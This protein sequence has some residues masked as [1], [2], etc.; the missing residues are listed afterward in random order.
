[1]ALHARLVQ[2]APLQT[3][4]CTHVQ[5]AHVQAYGVG[6]A[7]IVIQLHRGERQDALAQIVGYG[8]LHSLH[9]A[10]HIGEHQLQG[11]RSGTCRNGTLHHGIVAPFLESGQCQRVAGGQRGQPVQA[12]SQFHVVSLAVH[13]VVR[14]DDVAAVATAQ[15]RCCPQ[16]KQ[17]QQKSCPDESSHTLRSPICMT[18]V[19]SSTEAARWPCGC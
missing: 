9:V 11:V 3:A 6:L 17:V 15:Q 8:Q 10:P 4:R 12:G 2:H 13:S 18:P 5:H 1:M 19:R 16:H 7:L 14:V